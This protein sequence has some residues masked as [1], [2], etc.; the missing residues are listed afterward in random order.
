MTAI[1]IRSVKVQTNA[2]LR[3]HDPCTS[4]LDDYQRRIYVN[5]G[6]AEGCNYSVTTTLSGSQFDE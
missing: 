2:A 5:V 3:E 1:A 4:Q 6:L